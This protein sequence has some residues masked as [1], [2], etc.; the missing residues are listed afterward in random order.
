LGISKWKTEEVGI[1]TAYGMDSALKKLKEAFSLEGEVEPMT[2]FKLEDCLD[3]MKPLPFQ[4]CKIKSSSKT[5]C[6]AIVFWI[7]KTQGTL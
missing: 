2:I 4:L 7:I 3:I 1:G 6:C 5:V